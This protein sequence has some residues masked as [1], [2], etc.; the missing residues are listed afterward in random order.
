VDTGCSEGNYWPSPLTTAALMNVTSPPV[1]WQRLRI[2]PGKGALY[3]QYSVVAG[4]AGNKAP[5]GAIGTELFGEFPMQT[6]PRNW[7]YMM[8][9]CDWDN[10]LATNAQYWQRGDLTNMGNNGQTSR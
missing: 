4:P 2:A 6:P 1:R 9:Q 3:C 5:M 8:A 7:F 10:D